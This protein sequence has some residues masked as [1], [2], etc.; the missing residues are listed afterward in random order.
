MS[1]PGTV[2]VVV[3]IWVSQKAA[4]MDVWDDLCGTECLV[5]RKWRVLGKHLSFSKPTRMNALP[6]LWVGRGEKREAKDAI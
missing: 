3:D 2:Q 1:S 4:S 6:F 5:E